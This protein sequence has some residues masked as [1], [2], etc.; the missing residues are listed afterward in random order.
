MSAAG[1]ARTRISVIVCAYNEERYLGGCLHSILAQTRP[2]DEVIV[3]NNRSEDGTREIAMR[4]PMV[5]VVDEP[6][7]GLVRAREAGR[8][9]ASGDLLV[10][11]D[12]DSRLPLTWIELVV[13]KFDRDPRLVGLSGRYRFYDW[14]RLGTLLL[15]LYDVTLAPL[16]PPAGAPGARHRSGLLWRGVLR[17]TRGP[18]CHRRIR[19]HDRIPR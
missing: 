16:D 13:R 9:Y 8:R 10:Y 6:R 11:L 2:P 5:D 14:D 4:L 15:G 7:R 1:P 17:Q 18:R 3:V 19:Y 12:A